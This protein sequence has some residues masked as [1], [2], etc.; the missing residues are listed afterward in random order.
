VCSYCCLHYYSQ[1]G[2]SECSCTGAYQEPIGGDGEC[3]CGVGA[4]T[5][6]DSTAV[7]C[8]LCQ[9]GL[10]SLSVAND[11]CNACPHKTRAVNGQT[12]PTDRSDPYWACLPTFVPSP[13]NQDVC[14]CELGREINSK[15]TAC[16][17]CAPGTVRGS[18]ADQRCTPCPNGAL[19]VNNA[20]C[21]CSAGLYLVSR[22]GGTP[23]C[24]VCP[25]GAECPENA[26]L[27]DNGRW[28][29]VDADS[30]I[31]TFPCDTEVGKQ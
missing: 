25:S 3:A 19:A 9:S 6:D 10:V 1:V 30:S 17:P 31:K 16:D 22:N 7:R 28:Q 11:P 24:A 21:V 5:V 23:T 12:C 4:G 15:G 26:A 13:S 20:V 14:V 2:S 29:V 27:V 18:L 8:V